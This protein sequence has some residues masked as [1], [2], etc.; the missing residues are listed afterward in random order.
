MPDVKNP[1]TIY[2]VN[3]QVFIISS[4]NIKFMIK[5][6]VYSFQLKLLWVLIRAPQDVDV[7]AVLDL[8][9]LPSDEDVLRRPSPNQTVRSPW[10]LRHLFPAIEV[11]KSEKYLETESKWVVFYPDIFIS[12][13]L[14]SLWSSCEYSRIMIK[15]LWFQYWTR[16]FKAKWPARSNSTCQNS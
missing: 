5:S 1:P 12:K 11:Q 2:F 16:L 8:W 10:F 7:L 3:L 15:H 4:A 9:V 14:R 13:S 6:F